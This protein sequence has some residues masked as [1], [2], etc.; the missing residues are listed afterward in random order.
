MVLECVRRKTIKL[1]AVVHSSRTSVLN[2]QQNEFWNVLI[3]RFC[4][5]YL[6]FLFQLRKHDGANFQFH[7]RCATQFKRCYVTWR[8]PVTGTLV[9]CHP[10]TIQVIQ[11][12]N[13]PKGLIYRFV[14]PFI[15]EHEFRLLSIFTY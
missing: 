14:R 3:S 12:S 11:S 13:A 4:C 8:G 10:D 6:A 1:S 5:Q 15:G 2:P 9:L 7:I